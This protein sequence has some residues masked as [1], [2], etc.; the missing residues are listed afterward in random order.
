[1]LGGRGGDYAGKAVVSVM[2]ESEGEPGASSP[3]PAVEGRGAW[4]RL[5]VGRV[6]RLALGIVAA[7]VV[8]AVGPGWFGAWFDATFPH[9]V[10]RAVANG[11]LQGLRAG[12]LV[13]FVASVAGVV[14]LPAWVVARRRRGRPAGRAA[15]GLAL[16][17][18]TLVALLGAEVAASAFLAWEHRLPALPAT[19]PEAKE[20]GEIHVVVVGESSAEG[21]PYHPWLSVG[22]IVGWKL[23]EALPGR[24]VRVTV[25]A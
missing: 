22:Q 9:S 23:G 14:V 7:F 4:R 24:P 11:L 16:A 2:G 13:A 18:S 25:L 3:M 12:Y 21:Q 17:C 19:F 5:R 8:A 15:K 10:R 1:V 6:A 20:P